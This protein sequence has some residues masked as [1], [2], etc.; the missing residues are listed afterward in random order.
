MT[1]YVEVSLE[2]EKKEGEDFA[3]VHKLQVGW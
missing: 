1:I 3:E 2:L